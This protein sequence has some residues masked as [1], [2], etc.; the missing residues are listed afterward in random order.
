MCERCLVVLGIED[1]E[2]EYFFLRGRE[3]TVFPSLEGTGL[4]VDG[5]CV[6]ELCCKIPVRVSRM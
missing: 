5:M 3:R 1:G 6:F 4:L 2:I